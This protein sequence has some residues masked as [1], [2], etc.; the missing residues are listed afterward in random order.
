MRNTETTHT[1][2]A[3]P[4]SVGRNTRDNPVMPRDM[5]EEGVVESTVQM[6]KSIPPL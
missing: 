5:E 2:H 1:G 6:H 4:D 3:G